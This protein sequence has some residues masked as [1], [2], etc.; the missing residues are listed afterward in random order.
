VFE[1]NRSSDKPLYPSR[2]LS[3]KSN[4]LSPFTRSTSILLKHLDTSRN[5]SNY[6]CLPMRN[7]L[8]LILATLISLPLLSQSATVNG[9][10]KDNQSEA[11]AFANVILY[12]AS[13][14]TLAKVVSTATDG[15]FKIERIAPADYWLEVRYVGFTDYISP[16]F[17]LISNEEK[18]WGTIEL[19]PASTQIEGVE[20]VAK[21][22]LLEVKP[23]KIVFNV[24]G[25]VNTAGGD[26][27]SLLRKAPGVQVD[28]NDN[29]SLIGKTGVQVWI[30]DKPSPLQGDELAGYLRS[31]TADQIQSIEIISNPSARY[32]AEG[33]AGILNIRLK[34][35]ENHGT[36]TN[37]ELG[38]SN[39]LFQR[40]DDPFHRYNGRIG[41]NYRND[42]VNVFGSVGF[43]ERDGYSW[44]NFERFQSGVRLNQNFDMFSESIGYNYRAGADYYI[45][46]R[47]TIGVLS[48]GN[49]STSDRRNLANT[50]IGA[51]GASVIDSVLLAPTLTDA[52]NENYDFNVNFVSRPKE[53]QKISADLD[54]GIYNS[55]SL[56]EIPNEYQD[57]SGEVLSSNRI[58]YDT[59]SK[60]N[61]RSAK[62]DYER[63]WGPGT[64]ETGVKLAKVTNEADF[65][66]LDFNGGGAGVLIPED[67]NDFVYDEQV[68]AVY[69][70][71]N[72]TKEKLSYQ[73]GLRVEQ[74]VSEG[75]L[76][77]LNE[78]EENNVKRKYTDLFPSGGITYQVNPKNSL[79]LTYSRRLNRPY[80]ADLNPFLF[81][82]DE[83]T[84]EKGNPFLNPEYSHNI[85]LS[86]TLNYS[87]T[88]SLTYTRTDDMISRV[89]DTLDVV[90]SFISRFNIAQQDHIGLSFGAPIPITDWWSTYFSVS[91]Y[92]L[93][94]QADDLNGKPFSLEVAAASIYGQNS[95][96]LPKNYTMELSGYY[97]SPSV[98]EGTF[99][100]RRY[101]NLD[102][103]MGK[104][105]L[106]GRAKLKLAFSDILASGQW[107]GDSE[108]GTLRINAQGGW[109]SQRLRI[110]FSYN[111][112]NQKVRSRKRKTGI[113]T[114][115][116]RVKS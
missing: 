50:T 15:S 34:K 112:G 82:L 10:V 100:T 7:C 21:K 111:F 80:Y 81:Q 17:T 6:F 67:S 25:S 20:V 12:Q 2:V 33:N 52:N 30:D 75:D 108:L 41:S 79:Q 83:L 1:N 113:E 78:S 84:F 8:F 103:G 74:T 43:N 61:I 27:L 5:K 62:V 85:Q 37:L 88:T 39:S 58:A 95:F 49:V 96:T 26:A 13:D 40:F 16:V 86:H 4:V 53:G 64:F 109:D 3:A 31:L 116:G 101:Y 42:K 54:Y 71:Y 68:N 55:T 110:N 23:D 66:F 106:E 22:P 18:T 72:W 115:S 97:S 46:E 59:E 51:I 105:F 89:I 35:N 63:K 14:S 90:G 114:E 73:L 65:D 77:S 9:S 69:A 60:I 44:T 24:E 19:S 28:Y 94:N 57:T 45:N 91:G 48:N 47:S 36:N 29:I 11:A 99:R 92:W 32:D 104:T 70:N 56:Q 76:T 38:Y 102:I 98:W 107:W 87:I 93:H